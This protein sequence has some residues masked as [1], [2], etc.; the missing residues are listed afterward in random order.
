MQKEAIAVKSSFGQM[1][2]AQ[3]VM[4]YWQIET[5]NG[6][7]VSQ[8]IL[9]TIYQDLIFPISGGLMAEGFSPLVQT[10]FA[11]P[12]L[13]KGIKITF[14]P[15]S[16]LFGLRLNPLY[17]NDFFETSPANFIQGPNSLEKVLRASIFKS[18]SSINL[19]NSFWSLAQ[20]FNKV[21]GKYSNQIKE[22]Q[23]VTNSLEQIKQNPDTNIAEL[24]LQNHCSSKW[25]QV[26]FQK[27]LGA[28][29]YEFVKL[30]RFN[31]FLSLLYAKSDQN[32]TSLAIQ[33]G[34]YDQSHLIKE[35]KNFSAIAPSSLKIN[36]PDFY[37]I[38][39]HL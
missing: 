34:Y 1:E 9:P 17:V 18:L 22:N 15:D 37:R 6:P 29:P 39:N 26:Q 24:S 12:L 21:L 28:R 19:Q 7:E 5:N 36:Y 27:Q 13:K 8:T 30:S 4:F 16:C 25:L 10:P 11:G 33:A 14:M 38:M 35:F 31:R 2:H 20:Q 3:A 23:L 32:L